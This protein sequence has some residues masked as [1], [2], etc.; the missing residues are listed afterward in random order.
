MAVKLEIFS[1]NPPCPGCE[2]LLAMGDQIA[3]EYPKEELEVI[4]YIGEEGMAK[5]KEY[6]LFCVPAAVVNEKIRIEGTC[7][8]RNT[9]NNALREGGLWI[10]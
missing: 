2:A 4:K 1:G 6:G 3:A 9:M 10:R 7:P 8:T 5:F